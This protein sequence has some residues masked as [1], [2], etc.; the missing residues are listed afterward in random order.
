MKIII[1]EDEI[2]AAEKLTNFIKKYDS[3]IEILTILDSV[4]GCI[5]YFEKNEMPD[6]IFSDIELLDGNAFSFFKER[7]ITCPIIFATAYDEFLMKAFNENGIAYLLKPFD[8]KEFQQAMGKY[9]KLKNNFENFDDFLI[10]KIKTSFSRN[11]NDFKKRFAVKTAKGIFIINVD[12]IA[13]IRAEEGLVFCTT[14]NQ[15]KFTLNHSLNELE[16]LLNPDVFFRL[17]RSEI[18][19]VNFIEKLENYFNDR[20]SISLRNFEEKLISS[21]SRTSA[22]RRWIDK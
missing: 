4:R 9:E 19:N 3:K 14:K 11:E 17:N 5:S 16:Q 12:E 1:I 22:L 8:F 18:A 21:A 15:K 6:L 7:K 20:L 2:L 13:F 10:D